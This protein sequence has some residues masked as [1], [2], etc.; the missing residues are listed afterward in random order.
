MDT[1]RSNDFSL[2]PSAYLRQ[3][4]VRLFFS[5][6]WLALIPAVVIAGG[7]LLD[8]RWAVV[9]LMLLFIIFPMV[10]TMT[11]LRYGMAPGMVARMLVTGAELTDDALILYNV[12][13]EEKLRIA[14]SK[15]RSAS[16]HGS[17]LIIDFGRAPDAIVII[18]R[19][20]FSD[21]Q[22]AAIIDRFNQIFEF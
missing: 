5:Y 15:V 7:L 11:L 8:W 3:M 6:W 9:G 2:T 10:V 13:G 19:E 4:S 20:A 12:D 1:I 21:D 16:L 17:F 18:P 22:V 14:A